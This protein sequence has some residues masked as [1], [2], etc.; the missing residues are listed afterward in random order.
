LDDATGSDGF[1][2]EEGARSG[3][4]AHSEG[5]RMRI[6]DRGSRMAGK[7]HEGASRREDGEGGEPGNFELS[8]RTL[9][10]RGRD[11]GLVFHSFVVFFTSPVWG[12]QT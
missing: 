8:N 11:G 1:A 12:K 4:A 2:A 7:P 10:Y 6:E 9:K 5:N 3:A